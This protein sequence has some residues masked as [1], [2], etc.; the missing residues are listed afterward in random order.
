MTV[1]QEDHRLLAGLGAG[2]GDR[3]GD[4]LG[5]VCGEGGGLG[6]RLQAPPLVDTERLRRLDVGGHLRGSETIC[7]ACAKE[8]SQLSVDTKR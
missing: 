4:R 7:Y 2:L 6:G 8:L 1:L 3:L 5:D